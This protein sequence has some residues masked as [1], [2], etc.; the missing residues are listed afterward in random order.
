MH[1]QFYTNLC[2]LWDYFEFLLALYFW[3][4]F[5]NLS[6]SLFCTGFSSPFISVFYTY[7]SM[8][9]ESVDENINLLI[10]PTILFVF[11]RRPI[12]VNSKW[13]KMRYYKPQQN[14]Q[15]AFFPSKKIQEDGASSWA[16]VEQRGFTVISHLHIYIIF[17]HCYVFFFNSNL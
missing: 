4:S 8:W 10:S 1:L 2:K 3:Q 15:S 9:Y 5:I 11:T 6:V 12:Q 16:I 14:V 13:T 17:P 7:I